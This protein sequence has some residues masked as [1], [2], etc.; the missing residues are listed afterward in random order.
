MFV[1]VWVGLGFFF[2]LLTSSYDAINM[3]FH[4]YT[5][6]FAASMLQKVLAAV[7]VI[8]LLFVRGGENLRESGERS[9]V[10]AVCRAQ[11][12]IYLQIFERSM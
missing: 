12:F 8:G 11:T 4:G 2:S 7:A 10:S 9:V 6:T 3:F 1:Y 5:A